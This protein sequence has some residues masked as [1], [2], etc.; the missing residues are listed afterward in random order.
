MRNAD[1][2]AIWQYHDDTKHSVE[3]LQ[4]NRHVLDWEIQPLPYKIYRD[5][6]PLPLPRDWPPSDVP[7]LEAI[8]LS[9]ATAVPITSAEAAMAVTPALTSVARLLLFSAG[10]TRKTVYAGGRAMHFRAA[11][12]TGALYHIDLYLVCGALPGLDPGVYHFGPHDFALRRLRAGDYRALV[13]EATGGEPAVAAA[14]AIVVSASTF[15]RNAWKYQARAYRHCF[16]DEGTILANALAVAAADRVPARVV[17][18]F[19]DHTIDHLLGLDGEREAAL[20]LLAAGHDPDARP[21]P[22]PP[23]PPLVLATEPLSAREVG[24]PAI[25]A[26]HAASSL[27]SADEVRAWRDAP[28]APAP[29]TP[30]GPAV[31]LRPLATL[32]AEGIDSVIRRRGSARA[33]ARAAIRFEELSTLLEY[34]T[35]AVATDFLTATAARLSDLYLIVNA[36]EGLAAGTYI[37]HP[38]PSSLE[39]LRAGDF[40]REAG[41]LGL[42][43][44]LPADASVNFYL[45][46]DLRPVLARLGNRGYRA[47]QLEAAIRGGR[48]YLGAYALGLGASGLTFFDD[49]VIEFFSPHATGKSVMFLAAVGRGRKRGLPVVG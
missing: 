23:A 4:R 16:W 19:V 7:A 41:S 28:P 49:A 21:A 9:G 48:L 32:P 40:R 25:R 26:A 24:Y 3:R 20:S 2:A 44:D 30:A 29:P 13:V 12:C 33:F 43:Q 39:C 27:A 36:V 46:S 35:A 18:G 6:E 11:A 8:A 42:G 34:A 10:V 5:L 15:W 14:P 45:L 37:Y 31:A 17:L 22:A 1:L 47:A 38:S